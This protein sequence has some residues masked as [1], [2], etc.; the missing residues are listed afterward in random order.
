MEK[1]I[2]RNIQVI[3]ETNVQ[4]NIQVIDKTNL[5]KHKCH[6]LKH[7]YKNMWCNINTRHIQCSLLIKQ[8][9]R[10]IRIIGKTNLSHN[11]SLER[12][13]TSLICII[14]NYIFDKST[15]IYR[16][17]V[18]PER[19]FVEHWEYLTEHLIFDRASFCIVSANSLIF[20]VFDEHSC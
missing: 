20:S 14:Y 15:V 6:W 1:K 3:D 12:V 18:T 8:I 19:C 9:Y 5:Q 11:L 16:D 17:D 2:Y 4:T 13:I 7:L 10:N